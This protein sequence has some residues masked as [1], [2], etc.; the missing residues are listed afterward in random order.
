M[1]TLDVQPE[2]LPPPPKI[3]KSALEEIFE[4]EDLE[5]TG[6]F[7][8]PTPTEM[9][10]REV[11]DYRAAKS[12]SMKS[13][14]LD[15]WKLNSTRF[16]L[17]SQLSLRYLCVQASSVASERVFSTAGDTLSNERSKM[18]TDKVDMAIFI[19]KNL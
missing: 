16:P 13:N 9:A 19:K 18:S 1:E 15:F 10:K 11:A 12:I 5:I 17:L 14:P 3:K 6:V 8:P 7:S 4:D 2:L